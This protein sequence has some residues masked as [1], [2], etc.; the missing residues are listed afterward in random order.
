M[1]VIQIIGIYWVMAGIVTAG[2]QWGQQ[3]L[4]KINQPEHKMD[5]RPWG[6]LVMGGVILPA[7]MVA[8]LYVLLFRKKNSGDDA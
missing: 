1:S 6:L 8:S 2:W 4:K 3:E 5:V 7:A